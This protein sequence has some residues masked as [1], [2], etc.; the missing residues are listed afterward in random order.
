MCVLNPSTFAT[1]HMKF[2]DLPV[3]AAARSTPSKLQSSKK[4]HQPQNDF[5]SPTAHYELIFSFPTMLQTKQLSCAS[6]LSVFCK[7]L[8]FF[9][10][11]CFVLF[12]FAC[13][14]S[15]FPS[16]CGSCFAVT[17]NWLLLLFCSS[18]MCASTLTHTHAYKNRTLILYFLMVV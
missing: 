10:S 18:Y 4:P 6:F 12:C 17:I 5:H 3:I 1:N 8:W 13:L 15:F 9:V 11:I 16:M 14:C 7:V 2:L